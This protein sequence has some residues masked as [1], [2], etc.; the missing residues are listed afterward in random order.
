MFAVNEIY[1]A[2][3]GKTK[4]KLDRGDDFLKEGE[5]RAE[6]Y[7]ILV[8]RTNYELSAE[9]FKGLRYHE[10]RILTDDTCIA[11]AAYSLDGF[12]AAAKWFEE[13]FIVKF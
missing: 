13:N 9:A 1:N 7:K 5:Q 11:I 4:V 10:F 2:F 8:G 12:K 3:V 6:A